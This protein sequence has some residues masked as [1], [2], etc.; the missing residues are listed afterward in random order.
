MLKKS[1]RVRA[2]GGKSPLAHV[3]NEIAKQ[4]KVMP[5]AGVTIY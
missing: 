3:R 2:K 5:A 4:V 1:V